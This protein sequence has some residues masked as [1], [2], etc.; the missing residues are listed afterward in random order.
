MRTRIVITTLLAMVVAALSLSSPAAAGPRNTDRVPA[1]AVTFPPAPQGAGPSLAAAVSPGLSPIL[2]NTKVYHA[3]PGDIWNC[4]SGYF[5]T[6]VWDYT[7]N[8]WKAFD[9]YECRRY[10]LSN[11]LDDGEFYNRQT[12]NPTTYFYGE[13]GQTLHTDTPDDQVHGYNWDDVW[14]IRNC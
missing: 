13:N 3:D 14:S 6:G 4:A 10:A 12:G 9:L 2:A 8:R 1:G 11:W 5:C 7:V